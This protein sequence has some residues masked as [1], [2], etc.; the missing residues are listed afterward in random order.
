MDCSSGETN[1]MSLCLNEPT[2]RF[3]KTPAPRKATSSWA[4]RFSREKAICP[5][6]AGLWKTAKG[7]LEHEKANGKLTETESEVYRRTLGALA[8]I[9]ETTEQYTDELRLVDLA[10][11]EANLDWSATRGWPL[12]KLGRMDEARAAMRESLKSTDPVDRRIA[13]NT[14][15]SLEFSAWNYEASYSWFTLL[16]AQSP[17]EDLT[18]TTLSNR[19]ETALALEN[20]AGAE[21]DYRQATDRFRPGSYTNPWEEI[22]PLYV[23]TGRLVFAVSAIQK[24]RAWDAASDPTL[25]QNRWS[26]EQLIV[27]LVQLA[28]GRDQQAVDTTALLLRRPDRLGTTAPVHRNRR[29]LRWISMSKLCGATARG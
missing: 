26:R 7:L 1:S 13:L 5:L 28:A 6:P 14:L 10:R 21:A 25:E 12:M 8:D 15:G 24:M 4:L 3:A 23:Q 18:P 29:L 19:A 9:Y 17:P 27:G 16:I 2:M 20:F 22:T 11:R